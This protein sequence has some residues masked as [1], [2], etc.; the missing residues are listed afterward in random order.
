MGKIENVSK[1]KSCNSVLF[2]V[3]NTLGA[4][5]VN[6]KENLSRMLGCIQAIEEAGA[7]LES[8]I[9]DESEHEEMNDG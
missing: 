3:V 9:N 7:L 2:K 8:V 6:G 4:I 1:L 5:P